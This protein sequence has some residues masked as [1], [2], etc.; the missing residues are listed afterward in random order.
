MDGVCNINY[1]L[2]K[3]DVALRDNALNEHGIIDTPKGESR[4]ADRRTAMLDAAESLFLELGYEQTT[5]AAVVRRSGGSLATLYENFGNKQGLLRA[6]IARIAEVNRPPLPN[7]GPADRSRSEELRA[8][9]HSLYAHLTKPRNIALNRI[10][11]TEAL[12]DPDFARSIY[13]E[14][15]RSAVDELARLFALW[16]EQGH[17]RIDRPVAAADLFVAM[18]IGDT[19]LRVLCADTVELLTPDDLDW[20]LQAFVKHLQID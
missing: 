17:A 13:M 6:M 20:R 12:R 3:P 8:Y 10:V 11:M 4:R 18:I 5:L 1:T 7:S 9:A 19:K 14:I 15:H 2:V 16:A